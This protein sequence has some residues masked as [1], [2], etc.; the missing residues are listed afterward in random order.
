MDVKT[1]GGGAR[2]RLSASPSP[3]LASVSPSRIRSSP[4]A[5]EGGKRSRRRVQESV[6]P[7]VSGHLI[8]CTPTRPQGIPLSFPSP[9][10][11]RALKRGPPT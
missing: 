5:L 2:V 7:G 11:G 10:Q 6:R 4:A 1:G 3:E 9:A 8:P